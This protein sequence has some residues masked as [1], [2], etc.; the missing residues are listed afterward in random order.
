MKLREN[1]LLLLVFT[2]LITACSKDETPANLPEGEAAITAQINEEQWE[3]LDFESALSVVP[4]K[5][6]FFELSASGSSYRMNL[7][8][9]EFDRSTGTISEGN[10]EGNDIIFSLFLADE[11]GNYLFEYKPLEEE[12]EESAARI[13]VTASTNSRITGTFTGILHR[14]SQEEEDEY[15]E[16][17]II[18]DGL[19][20]NLPFETH[21]VN[22]Q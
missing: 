21:T 12:E 20:N 8:I 3:A 2:L 1:I 6:Q 10:Y 11:E 4:G 22:I 19:F 5:G 9:L 7:S 16:F 14:I 17:L 18:T 13:I 15:P